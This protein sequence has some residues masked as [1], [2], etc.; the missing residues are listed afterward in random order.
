MAEF[1][2]FLTSEALF[3]IKLIF[4]ES[5]GDASIRYTNPASSIHLEMC[6][7]EA[8]YT[9]VAQNIQLLSLVEAAG[10]IGQSAV[11]DDSSTKCSVATSHVA[12]SL[13]RTLS[14]KLWRKLSDHHRMGLDDAASTSLPLYY[15]PLHTMAGPLKRSATGLLSAPSRTTSQALFPPSTYRCFSVLNRPPPNYEGHI[16]LTRTERLGLALGSGL[17]SFLDPRRGGN[18]PIP[19]THVP[20]P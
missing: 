9:Q 10:S 7:F 2:V 16:P 12:P 11:H 8:S 13:W 6:S 3:K 19:P 15:T 20:N 18:I 14:I 4:S 17:L 1:T 5:L